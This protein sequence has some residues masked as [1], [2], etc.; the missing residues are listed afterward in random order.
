M[1][2]VCCTTSSIRSSPIPFSSEVTTHRPHL[3][4]QRSG[5]SPSCSNFSP[6]PLTASTMTSSMPV[7]GFLLNETPEMTGRTISWMM[8][9]ISRPAAS[10]PALCA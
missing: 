10:T 9:P 8:T 4:T 2:L 1:D 6:L 5:V 7:I 3:L